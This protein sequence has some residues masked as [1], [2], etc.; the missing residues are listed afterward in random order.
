MFS[1]ETMP[2]RL[3]EVPSGP[4]GGVQ[5]EGGVTNGQAKSLT[6][7]FIDCRPALVGYVVS[8]LNSSKDAEDIVQETYIRVA[9][10]EQKEK[11][12]FPKAFI[13]RIARN[14]TVDHLRWKKRTDT[15]LSLN[16]SELTRE[17]EVFSPE[18]LL[19]ADE[20]L[21]ILLK[22]ILGLPKKCQRVYT[23]RRIYGL[24]HR[25]I[26][27]ELGISVRTVENHIAKATKD[28]RKYLSE[29]FADNQELGR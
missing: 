23:L 24:S 15:A 4:G 20:Q 25:E 1:L 13:F 11:V 14:L 2:A 16:I 26:A 9:G 6:E 3:A 17:A 29:H 19:L 7:T 18:E 22:A 28:C 27:G 8:I 10:R 5:G 12:L 21:R